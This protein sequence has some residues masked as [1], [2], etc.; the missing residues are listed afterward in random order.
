[1]HSSN[2]SLSGKILPRGLN[3]PIILSSA[4]GWGG[5]SKELNSVQ[6]YFTQFVPLAVN[7]RSRAPPKLGSSVADGSVRAD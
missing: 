2:S 4:R 6:I 3:P 1:M 5:W 7:A